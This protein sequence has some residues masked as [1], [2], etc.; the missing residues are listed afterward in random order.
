MLKRGG[1]TSSKSCWN[2]QDGGR[3]GEAGMLPYREGFSLSYRAVFSHRLSLWP[4]PAGTTC[5]TCL[6]WQ[7]LVPGHRLLC[8]LSAL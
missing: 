6:G 7:P 5:W 3:V 1:G 2:G 4:V 8:F